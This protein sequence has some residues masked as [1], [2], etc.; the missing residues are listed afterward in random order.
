MARVSNA[1]SFM[2][3]STFEF[4]FFFCFGVS[5]YAKGCLECKRQSR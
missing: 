2:A 3:Q 5:V 1:V 4:L